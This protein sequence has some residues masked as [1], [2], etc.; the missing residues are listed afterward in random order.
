MTMAAIEHLPPPSMEDAAADERTQ[1]FWDAAA[2]GELVAPTCSSCGTMRMPPTR[3][4]PNCLSMELEYTT[5]PGTGTVFTSAVVR[6]AQR[7]DDAGS[8]PYV[9]ALIDA[10][11]APGIR[12]VS[13]VVNCDP[14]SVTIGMPVKV[15]F[16]KV[17]DT[18]TLPLWEPA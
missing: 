2:A 9:A 5:L 1:P 7:G 3:I 18:L 17:S 11:G 13:N 6:E 12:F 10:D 14:D 4:C 8:V 16:H 15:V